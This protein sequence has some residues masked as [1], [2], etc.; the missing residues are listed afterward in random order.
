MTK[1]EKAQ[2]LAGGRLKMADV[3]IEGLGTVTV[4]GLTRL[5][6]S[7]VRDRAET[8]AR[9]RFILAAGM[10]SPELTE[11]EAGEW[12]KVADADEIAK[13][14][15]KIGALSGLLEDSPR[16]TFPSDGEQPGA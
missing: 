16:E 3:V 8:D 6:A 5:E 12:M 1:A 15:M 10:V 9:E 7:Q 13:V 4:R 14:S 2:L 11:A